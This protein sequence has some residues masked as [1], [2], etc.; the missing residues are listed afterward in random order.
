[1]AD[2]SEKLLIADKRLA[3]LEANMDAKR[4]TEN[5]EMVKRLKSMMKEEIA[6]LKSKVRET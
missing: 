2:Q 1:M 6:T 3:E 4:E 5:E